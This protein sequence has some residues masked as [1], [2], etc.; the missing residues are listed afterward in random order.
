MGVESIKRMCCSIRGAD[1]SSS[2]IS[3]SSLSNIYS[4]SL[5]SSLGSNLVG[6]VS[7]SIGFSA[8]K[9]LTDP[10][11]GAQ[12]QLISN[13]WFSMSNSTLYLYNQSIPRFK[14]EVQVGRYDKTELGGDRGI[15][16]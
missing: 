12:F 3:G 13:H 9:L 7:F 14:S 6:E 5:L 16:F 1:P 2:K 11:S 4:N 10:A 8:F 15:V